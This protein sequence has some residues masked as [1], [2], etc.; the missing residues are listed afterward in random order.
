MS[1]GKKYHLTAQKASGAFDLMFW[2]ETQE[3]NN[4]LC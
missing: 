1:G 4:A 3:P 2:D